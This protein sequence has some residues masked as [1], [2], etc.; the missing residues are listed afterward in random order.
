MGFC[1]KVSERQSPDSLRRIRGIVISTDEASLTLAPCPC[2]HDSMD[3][4][5]TDSTMFSCHARRMA[6]SQRH[7]RAGR[8]FENRPRAPQCELTMPR[9]P[10]SNRSGWYVSL[11]RRHESLTND[12]PEAACPRQF[13]GSIPLLS[14]NSKSRTGG[15]AIAQARRTSHPGTSYIGNG[16][17][18]VCFHLGDAKQESRDSR[19]LPN[20]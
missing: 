9:S 5:T 3:A 17:A 20:C 8:L 2:K 15:R 1:R 12:S 19:D 16:R 7:F 18:A 13:P 14:S 10:R 6:R 4:S 11:A